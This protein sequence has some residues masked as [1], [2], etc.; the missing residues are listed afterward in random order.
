MAISLS[1]IAPRLTMSGWSATPPIA[2]L[3][4]QGANDPRVKPAESEQIIA[5]IEK[6]HGKVIY[7][8]YPDEGHGFARPQNRTDFNAR[9]EAFLG[10]YLGGRVEPLQGTKIDGSTAIVRVGGAA[11]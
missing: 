5:A 9:A 7:A 6:N 4:G 3:I 1:S 8:L 11:P 2:R 10:A